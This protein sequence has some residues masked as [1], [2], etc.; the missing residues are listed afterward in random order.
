MR[1]LVF[2]GDFPPLMARSGP[3]NNP[4][5]PKRQQRAGRAAYASGRNSRK[6]AGRDSSS[7]PATLLAGEES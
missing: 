3:S 4:A 1:V 6:Y 7:E 2:E 5:I